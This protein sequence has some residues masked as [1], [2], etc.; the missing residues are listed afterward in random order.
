[1]PQLPQMPR[2]ARMA[3]PRALDTSAPVLEA[4]NV[5]VRFGGL[6]AVDGASLQVRAGQIV[7]L[8]GPNGA[9][10]TTLFNAISGLLRPASGRVRLFG[11]E[12]SSMA[13]HQR[14][15]LGLSRT[16]QQIGLS[17]D[18]SVLDNMLMA[19]HVLS[20]YSSAGALVYTRGVA[21][22][23]AEMKD[24]AM[25]AIAALGFAGREETPVRLLSGGQQRIVEVACALL[26]DPQ[27]LMLDEP[28]AGMSPAAAE[29]LADRLRD[30]RDTQS[31]TVLLIEHNV[32][33]VLDVCD[34]V[35]VLNFGKVL[36]SGT[37]TEIMAHPDV[38]SAYLGEAAL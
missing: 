13:A 7:G 24:R 36:T 9:G 37:P 14:A 6:T 1:M 22:S 18:Q 21:T 28:S 33:L 2:P 25:L 10:K 8:I 27:L 4:D 35:Y 34:Y 31:R 15:D 19:Q 20:G 38:V 11:R 23:E 12:V 16:F 30:L 3:A 5:T 32:P 17:K 26:T 29:S